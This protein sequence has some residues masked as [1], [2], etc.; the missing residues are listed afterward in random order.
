[1]AGGVPAPLY[2]I[3][4]QQAYGNPATPAQYYDHYSNAPLYED[5][6]ATPDYYGQSDVYHNDLPQYGTESFYQEDTNQNFSTWQHEENAQVNCSQDWITTQLTTAPKWET[7]ECS[8]PEQQNVMFMMTEAFSKTSIAMIKASQTAA[9]PKA[10][11]QSGL[12]RCLS[13]PM[14]FRVD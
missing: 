4:G 6:M 1:M 14:Y 9:T 11:L 7:G 10:A 13:R 3:P 12:A 8:C 2:P 5:N